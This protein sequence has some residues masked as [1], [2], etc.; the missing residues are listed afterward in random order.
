MIKQE[1]IS[2]SV[3]TTEMVTHTDPHGAM[4]ISH[5]DL[6]MPY[7]HQMTCYHLSRKLMMCSKDTLVFTLIKEQLLQY[8]SSILSMDLE[9]VSLLRKVSQIK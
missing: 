7:I 3:N 6:M 2:L 1:E 5:K 9:H 4:F 8:T